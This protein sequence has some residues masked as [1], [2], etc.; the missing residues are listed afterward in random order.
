[1]AED[2]CH[3]AARLHG[4]L[5][6]VRYDKVDPVQNVFQM[7]HIRNGE[8]GLRNFAGGVELIEKFIVEIVAGEPEKFAADDYVAMETRGG[9]DKSVYVCR[10]EYEHIADRQPLR[11]TV[12]EVFDCAADNVYDL[13]IGVRM[14]KRITAADE[15]RE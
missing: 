12:A 2:R 8:L 13:K 5:F 1:M 7:Q 4:E 10:A 9:T 3:A 15:M 14:Q 6:V 11:R